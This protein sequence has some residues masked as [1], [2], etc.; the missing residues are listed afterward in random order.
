[1]RGPTALYPFGHTGFVPFIFL[2]EAPRAQVIVYL[3]AANE[4]I[5]LLEAL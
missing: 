3:G 2:V 1:M 5:F 4:E